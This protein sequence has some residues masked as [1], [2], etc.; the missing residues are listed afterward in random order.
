MFNPPALPESLMSDDP[1]KNQRRA[2]NIADMG[3]NLI[4]RVEADSDVEAADKWIVEQ[5]FAGLAVEDPDDLAYRAPNGRL[6]F[7]FTN[8]ELQVY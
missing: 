6:H 7:I 4:A 3:D 1:F 2:Y 5:G 8:Y